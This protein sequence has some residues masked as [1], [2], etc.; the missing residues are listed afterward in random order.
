MPS[1]NLK[2]HFDAYKGPVPYVFESYSHENGN[3]VFPQQSSISG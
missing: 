2:L 3:I 1:V